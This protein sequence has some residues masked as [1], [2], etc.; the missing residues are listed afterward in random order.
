MKLAKACADIHTYTL[1][2][3]HFESVLSLENDLKNSNH[4]GGK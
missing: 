3:V 1:L 4:K 2:T